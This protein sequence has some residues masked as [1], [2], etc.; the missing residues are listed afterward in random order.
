MATSFAQSSDAMCVNKCIKGA[1]RR[2]RERE[3][4]RAMRR[5]TRPQRQAA[6]LLR[7][8]S[9]LRRA[10]RPPQRRQK[11][12]QMAWPRARASKKG[13]NLSG[14]NRPR[15]GNDIRSTNVT[16]S[17]TGLKIQGSSEI[18]FFSCFAQHKKKR[19]N[20]TILQDIWTSQMRQLQQKF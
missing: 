20:S 16:R 12:R 5:E 9:D 2:E 15:G 10:R 4:P 6:F 13:C 1:S 17:C 11:E 18:L 19:V 3:K 7:N 8:K 14:S